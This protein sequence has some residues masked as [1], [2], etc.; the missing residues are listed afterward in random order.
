LGLLLNLPPLPG[1]PHI[2]NGGTFAVDFADG[3]QDRHSIKIARGWLGRYQECNGLHKFLSGGATVGG[4]PSGALAP[5][6]IEHAHQGTAPGH[7]KPVF[8]RIRITDQ[9][10]RRRTVRVR[11][12]NVH[13]R[14]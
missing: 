4:V 7:K 13:A 5:L 8:F 9:F 3:R 12:R 10:N 2:E 1:T 11:L 14:P 6:V